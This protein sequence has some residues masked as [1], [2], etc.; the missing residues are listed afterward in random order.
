MKVTC[1]TCKSPLVVPDERVRAAGGKTLKLTCPKCKKAMFVRG[2]AP[3]PP[4]TQA[5]IDEATVAVDA[6]TMQS[7]LAQL[8][9]R[10]ERSSPT[11]AAQAAARPVS[12]SAASALSAARVESGEAAK[13]GAAPIVLPESPSPNPRP[14][15][16]KATPPPVPPAV[17]H[18]DDAAIPRWFVTLPTGKQMGPISLHELQEAVRHHDIG[19]AALVW[20]E[21]MEGWKAAGLVPEIAGLM[22]PRPPPPPPAAS[23]APHAHSAGIEKGRSG[24]VELDTAQ[25]ELA[26]LKATEEVNKTG[27]L[28]EREAREL[29]TGAF[30]I[31]DMEASRNAAEGGG[32]RPQAQFRELDARA[33]GAED[34]MEANLDAVMADAAL[35][36]EPAVPLAPPPLASSPV[37]AMAHRGPQP[38]PQL[39]VVPPVPLVPRMSA[40]PHPAEPAAEHALVEELDPREAR[41]APDEL[42]ALLFPE[43]DDGGM[44][45]AFTLEM[46]ESRLAKAAEAERA[47]KEQAAAR[48]AQQQAA[49]AR[50]RRGKYALF[51]GVALS[52]LALAVVAILVL[53]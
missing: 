21:G 41:R 40:L 24:V 13:R 31:A 5:D 49:A 22:V 52:V 37:P 51:A 26:T 34:D 3:P 39:A 25:F 12:Y 11:P 16:A 27:A 17:P 46:Y 2:A 43:G 20:R 8:D 50:A 23:A 33:L 14:P 45:G 28:K 47:R 36:P 18:L 29:D 35:V 7:L 6:G 48:L 10:S 30:Q 19:P 15:A 42:D 44:T 9:A 32:L 38:Q 4:V 53:R 1:Q